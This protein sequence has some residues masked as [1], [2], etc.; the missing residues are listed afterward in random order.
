MEMKGTL[1]IGYW[2]CIWLTIGVFVLLL[3][4]ACSKNKGP[5]N[6]FDDPKN[7]PPITNNPIDSL[8]IDNFAGL[9]RDIFKKTCSNSGCHDGTFEPD[10]RT[11]ESS[12]NTLVYQ[13]VIKNNPSGSFV[14]RV[15]PGNAQASVLYER[16][17]RDIDGISGIMPLS[18]DP[19]SDWPTRK[20][21]Y[22]NAI[23]AWINAGAKDMFGNPPGNGPANPKIQGVVFGE[24]DA[25]L[26]FMGGTPPRVVCINQVT[27]VRYE[28][29]VKPFA[30]G[31]TEIGLFAE[32][33]VYEHKVDLD[34]LPY[35]RYLIWIPQTPE[36]TH[37]WI[38]RRLTL[39]HYARRSP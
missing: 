1:R 31:K 21:T 39:Q 8:G 10:F 4:G 37:D 19:D 2:Q 28:L 22:I 12:Y 11:I 7:K 33:V 20:T 24:H 18:V 5:E 36:P 15:V 27:G 38:R 6:P 32:S 3:M 35:G 26:S 30:S 14:H 13:P 23:V 29:P 25:I 16:V 17:V 9:Q 34:P